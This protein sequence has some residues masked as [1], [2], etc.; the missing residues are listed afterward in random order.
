MIALLLSGTTFL[1]ANF[2]KDCR[3]SFGCLHAVRRREHSRDER[4]RGHGPD[5]VLR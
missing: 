2:R 1:N 5:D 3:G 4:R